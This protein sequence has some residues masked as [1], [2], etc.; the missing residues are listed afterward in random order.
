MQSIPDKLQ[1]V[2]NKCKSFGTHKLGFNQ[3]K[4]MI[5][6]VEIIL[7]NKKPKTMT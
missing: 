2:K 5:I 4:N 3:L 1:I 7:E 6:Y